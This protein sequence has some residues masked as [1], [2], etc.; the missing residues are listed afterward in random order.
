MP[1]HGPRLAWPGRTT[2]S[3]GCVTDTTSGAESSA[4]GGV[5][6]MHHETMAQ[7]AYANYLGWWL[8]DDASAPPPDSD[9]D[10]VPDANDRCPTQP[11]SASY[12]RCPLRI[13]V[14]TRDWAALVK[15]GRSMRAGSLRTGLWRFVDISGGRPARRLHD[16]DRVDR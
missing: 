14:I 15:E 1:V 11:G 4:A 5:R 13:G 16:R 7:H 8:P 3:V 9:G 6:Q 2:R 10:G 12:S